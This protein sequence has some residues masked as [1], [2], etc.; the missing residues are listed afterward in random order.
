MLTNGKEGI[1]GA[2]EVEGG[3]GCD[4]DDTHCCKW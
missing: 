1:S 4:E 2:E 3:G